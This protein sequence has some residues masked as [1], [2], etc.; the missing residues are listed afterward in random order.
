M[1]DEATSALAGAAAEGVVSL[2]EAGLQGMVTL[3]ADLATVAEA[4]KSVTGATMP[5][6]RGISAGPDM[7]VA[8]MSPDEI[9]ILCAHGAADDVATRLTTAL[10]DIPHLAVNV[11]DARAVFVLTGPQGALRD[12][13]A[14][15]TPADMAALSPGEMRRTRL[16]QV[17]AAIWFESDEEARVVCFR[18]V[19]RY[20]FDL[21]ELSARD[22]GE[23]GYH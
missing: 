16:Q 6:P 18:S 5:D 2:R 22:G 7:Q 9:L 15:V 8:W 3:R 10:G 1:S 17:A 12:T 23:V 21:L 19:A 13:L 4:V 20:V 11:S 14:K